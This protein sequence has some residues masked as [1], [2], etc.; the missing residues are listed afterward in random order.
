MQF[1]LASLLGMIDALRPEEERQVVMPA[2]AGRYDLTSRLPTLS[3]KSES[4]KFSFDDFFR[5]HAKFRFAN[6]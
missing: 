5:P 1:S 3:S 6:F 4:H 2:K